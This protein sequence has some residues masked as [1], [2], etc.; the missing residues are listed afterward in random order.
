MEGAKL[1]L[2]GGWGRTK[3]KVWTFVSKDLVS[4][5]WTVK[6]CCWWILEEGCRSQF[7]VVCAGKKDVETTDAKLLAKQG[8]ESSSYPSYSPDLAPSNFPSLWPPRMLFCEWWWDEKAGVKSSDTSVN[9]FMWPAYSVSCKSGKSVLIMKRVWK[10]NLK[11]VKDVP[12]R[13][14]NFIIIVMTVSEKK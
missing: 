10:N 8:D 4:V 6:K 12:M 5:F 13:Y 2:W 9:S 3:F 7:R 11:F 1:G 14:V